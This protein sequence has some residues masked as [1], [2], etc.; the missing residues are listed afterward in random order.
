MGRKPSIT[1]ISTSTARSTTIPFS[2]IT[3]TRRSLS[4]CFPELHTIDIANGHWPH[5]L[6]D[7]H[8]SS[9]LNASDRLDRHHLH[10]RLAVHIHPLCVSPSSSDPT[11]QGVQGS[12]F[13][14]KSTIIQSHHPSTCT[15]QARLA[16]LT[17][18]AST[19][20]FVYH[21]HMPIP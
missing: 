16:G 17:V 13:T 1:S 20:P 19:S 9:V 21:A 5:F 12:N 2:T 3:T 14:C 4:G 18:L 11:K 6:A 10:C 7:S 15:S 8:R